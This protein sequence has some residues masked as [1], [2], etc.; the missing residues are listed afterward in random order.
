LS[1]TSIDY[2]SASTPVLRV[3]LQATQPDAPDWLPGSIRFFLHGEL[4]VT[5]GLFLWLFRHCRGVQLRN[6]DSPTSAIRL[7]S[8]ALRAA[9]FEPA[10]ALFPWPRLASEGYRLLQEFFTLP[11]KFL[12]FELA[13]VEAAARIAKGKLEIRFEF[14][15]PPPLPAQV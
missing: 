6:P 2:P 8:S 15:R 5:S 12:F 4:S 10:E 9:G 13:G 1:A 11:Q 7:S 14:D 3:L